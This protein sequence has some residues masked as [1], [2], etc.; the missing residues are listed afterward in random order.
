MTV[1]KAGICQYNRLVI[2]SPMVCQN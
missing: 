2:I 1:T